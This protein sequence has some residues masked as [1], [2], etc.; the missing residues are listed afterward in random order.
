MKT[1]RAARV[2]ANRR[3]PMKHDR[4]VRLRERDDRRQFDLSATDAQGGSQT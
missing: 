4:L 1:T 2:Q 3:L